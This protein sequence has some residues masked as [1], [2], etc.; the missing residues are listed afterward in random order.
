[1]WRKR[2]Q[3]FSRGV[4]KPHEPLFAPLL[5]GVAAQIE[6]IPAD[7]MALDG[8]RIRKN[9]GELR[10]A[11]GGNVVFSCAPSTETFA[12]LSAFGG[13]DHSSFVSQRRF[14]ASLDAVRQW[15]ADSSEPVIAAAFFGP[16]RHLQS[17]ID[18]QGTL[19]DVESWY[20][21]VGAN[22]AALVRQFAEAGVHLMQW[23]D[24]M[25]DTEADIQAWKGA[26]GTMGNIARFHR[27]APLLI[28]DNP[29]VPSWPAQAIACPDSDQMPG[30]SARPCGRAWSADPKQWQTQ[31]EADAS[32]RVITTKEEVA[33]GTSIDSLLGAFSRG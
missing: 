2:M 16:H 26:L 3:D 13:D 24:T 5:F 17:I 6:S 7:D 19:S 21:H 25:P 31:S 18:K 33:V 20:E 4:G 27:V 29:A 10:G 22:L 1:M 30:A 32:T 11:L 8:T 23:Y 28:L 14:E 15:Q 9:V 12:R